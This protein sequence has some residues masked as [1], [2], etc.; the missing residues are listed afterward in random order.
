MW[1]GP[2]SVRSVEGGANEEATMS[3][4]FEL[5]R[6]KMLAGLGT[7]GVAGAGAGMGT[8]ALYSDSESSTGNTIEAGTSNM[9]V[10][11]GLVEIDSSA[12]D[13][14]DA[15]IEGVDGDSARIDGGPAVNLNVGD[16]K[17]GDCIILRATV[18]V[19]GNP[20]YVALDAQNVDNS[21]GANPEPEDQTESEDDGELAENLDIVFGWDSDRT[22]LHDNSLEGS[23]NADPN[24]T[25]AG[26]K[27]LTDAG[28]GILYR[29]RNEASGD[30]PGGHGGNGASATRIGDDGN[31]DRGQVTH[32]IEV[33][34][35]ESVGNIVQGDSVDF[36]LVWNAEQVRNNADPT[37]SDDLFGG[38]D[39]GEPNTT[40]S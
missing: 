38:D 26:D 33:C 27:F 31:A 25:Y 21:G 6:R 14:V 19:V 1:V 8:T 17:P 16:M 22:D 4:K 23:I 2:S 36:D 37:D 9:A 30:P 24:G 5:S 35:P 39:P 18:E 29:G 3:D 10:D 13:A 32:F 15:S 7:I 20:M 34:L 11:F 12:P 40:Q 28:N